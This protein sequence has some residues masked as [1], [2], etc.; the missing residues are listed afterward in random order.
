M[1]RGRT[2]ARAAVL[3]AAFGAALAGIVASA[4]AEPFSPERSAATLTVT[5]HLT[6]GGEDLPASH[7]RHV[8]WSVD[9]RYAVKATLVA[10]K[11]SGFGGL[12]QPDAA[13]AERAAAAQSAAGNMQDMMAQ[14]QK[15]MEKCGDDEAC[16][17][18]ET[19]KMAQGIDPN[20][21]QLQQAKKDMEKAGAMPGLRYQ[22]FNGDR[23]SG[24]Y[25]IAEQ[26]REAYFDAACSLKNE[27]TCATDTAV[28]GDGTLDDG[29]GGTTFQAGIMA[30]LDSQAG[31]LILMLPPPGN[32]AVKR[33][34]KSP[35]PGVKVG[36][37]DDRR[38][39]HDDAFGD[40]IT[41][42]CGDCRTAHGTVTRDVEDALL[43]RPAKLVIEW[44]FVRP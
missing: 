17:Q 2:A 31:S 12:H 14:A 10:Q 11:P 15:I 9:N 3:L 36:T 21:P 4:R 19:I 22:M 25:A 43:G 35:N 33:T 16:I 18:T 29:N 40:R 28:S 38:Q 24:T 27:P 8:I 39:L 7:E 32:A 6:G 34:V 13:E 44:T 30:E 20:S 1:E 26:A 5:Y 23:Q 37:F 41:V 42:S